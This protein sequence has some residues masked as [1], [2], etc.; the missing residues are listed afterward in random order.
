MDIDII[1]PHR[2]EQMGVIVVIARARERA[3]GDARVPSVARDKG[4]GR[5]EGGDE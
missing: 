3:A 4:H 2:H 5:R 1:I